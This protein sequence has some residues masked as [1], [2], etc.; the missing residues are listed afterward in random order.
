V[1]AV[2]QSVLN[3]GSVGDGKIFVFDT[4]ETVRVRTGESGIAAV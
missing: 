1:I 2:M 4:E 3:T